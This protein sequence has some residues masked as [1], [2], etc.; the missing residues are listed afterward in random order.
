VTG[1]SVNV[2]WD[3]A[4]DDFGRQAPVGS[5]FTSDGVFVNV[6]EVAV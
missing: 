1:N 6:N 2:A 3:L 5:D 4:A